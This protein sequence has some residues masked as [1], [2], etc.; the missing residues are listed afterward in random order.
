MKTDKIKLVIWD[1]DETFWKGTLSEEGITYLKANH[2]IVVELARRGIANSISSK[3]DYD[4]AKSELVKHGIWEYFVFPKIDWQPKGQKIAKTIS[5][6][7]LRPVNVLF[8]DDNKTNIAEVE[9][10][11]KGINCAGPEIIGKLLEMPQLK[12]KN[13]RKLTRLNQYR[14][15]EKKVTDKESGSSD[16]ED[17]LRGC[18]IS[19]EIFHDC[20]KQSARILELIERTNQLNFTKKRISKE[21]LDSL[22]DD[23]SIEKAYIRVSD[24]YGDYGIAGFYAIKD[25][26]LLHFV[27][28]CRILD[29]GIEQYI[30]NRLGKPKLK[31]IKPVSS[32]LEGEP[33]WITEKS[34]GVKA[35]GKKQAKTILLRGGCDLSLVE[36][37][38]GAYFD[39]IITEFQYPKGRQVIHPDNLEVLRLAEKKPGFLGRI[40]FL[41][42]KAFDTQIFDPGLD[43]AVYSLLMDM[44]QG[45]YKHK[46][47]ALLPYGGFWEDNAAEA[48]D[49]EN[50]RKWF[51]EEFKFIGKV[52]K[53]RL[54]DNIH[55]L[56]KR[57]KSRIVFILPPETASKPGEEEVA[58]HYAS[59]NKAARDALKRYKN[60]GI[61]EMRELAPD[62]TDFVDS[63]RHYRRKVYHRIGE[64][65]KKIAGV[66]G[67]PSI[68][69]ML[70]FK[71]KLYMIDIKRRLR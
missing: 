44:T 66:S 46:S 15:L 28:S 3:N 19:I 14:I 16:N 1:L 67:R 29:M 25:D 62:K 36:D 53:E 64:R 8:I 50:D 31:I 17:F 9:F 12:G 59:L 20:K 68:G 41:D 18:D 5:D 23:D 52:T 35:T 65:L 71:R 51:E 13:D 49:S 21:E 60:T 63:I 33:D 69:K 45:I 48:F 30:Y 54:N 70:S 22:L 43:L 27:F 7:R 38:L 58:R 26:K 2:D 39:N 24:K 4:K 56:M 6:M 37:Y 55:W 34:A 42:R 11:N 61:L 40:P 57:V 47:G 32:R 10:Y